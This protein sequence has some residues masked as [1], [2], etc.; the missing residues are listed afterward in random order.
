M[1]TCVGGRTS[2]GFQ[3]LD[4]SGGTRGP[5]RVGNLCAALVGVQGSPRSHM[6]GPDA[7]EYRLSCDSGDCPAGWLGPWSCDLECPLPR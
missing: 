7:P 4:G 6:K 3:D 5:G 2:T 1:S